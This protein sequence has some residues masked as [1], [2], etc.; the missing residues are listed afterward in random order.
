[1]SV[2]TRAQF[3]H[4]N[5]EKYNWWQDQQSKPAHCSSHFHDYN[6]TELHIPYSYAKLKT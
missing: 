6:D 2:F 1:M 3:V 4:M 5:T